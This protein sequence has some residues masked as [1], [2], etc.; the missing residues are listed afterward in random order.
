MLRYTSFH[1]TDGCWSLSQQLGALARRKDNSA[2]HKTFSLRMKGFKNRVHYKLIKRQYFS[3]LVVKCVN[4]LQGIYKM[5]KSV[6]RLIFKRRDFAS[7]NK[8][9]IG[10]KKNNSN[11]KKKTFS[12]ILCN[13]IWKLYRKTSQN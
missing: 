8:H 2:I 13:L 4:R 9:H 6:G 1:L 11:I 12:L 7:Y 3:K 10:K 5:V